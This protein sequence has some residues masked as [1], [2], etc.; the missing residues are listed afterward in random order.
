MEMLYTHFSNIYTLLGRNEV[1]LCIQTFALIVQI[2]IATHV[3]KAFFHSR[4]HKFLLGCLLIMS[5]MLI[6]EHFSWMIHLIDIL[7]IVSLPNQVIRLII[8]SAWIGFIIRYQALNLFISNIL[9]SKPYINGYQKGLLSLSSSVILYMIYLAYIQYNAED[10][11][12][13]LFQNPLMLILPFA[14]IVSLIPSFIHLFLQFKKPTVPKILK[15]QTKLLVATFIAPDFILYAIYVGMF[16]FVDN[17]PYETVSTLLLIYGMYYGIKKIFRFTF[18]DITIPRFTVSYIKN[19]SVL[20][21]SVTRL[22]QAKTFTELKFITQ[23][24]FKEAFG[25]PFE[26][27]IL[28]IRHLPNQDLDSNTP[29]AIINA[30]IEKVLAQEKSFALQVFQRNQIIVHDEIEFD[31]FYNIRPHANFLYK[32][33]NDLNAELF[34]PI[35]KEDNSFVAYICISEQQGDFLFTKKDKNYISLFICG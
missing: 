34:I 7:G 35:F 23:N 30:V 29:Y 5:S 1:L 28:Y 3:S 24:F 2:I 9:N 19:E 31:A 22:K 15:D 17:I 11:Q 13:L 18:L 27:T 8:R 26:D 25:I 20:N 16:S 10:I 21:E 12:Y 6:L 4:Q 14:T 32:I 33:L